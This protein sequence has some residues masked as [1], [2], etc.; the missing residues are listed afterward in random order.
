MIIYERAKS[1]HGGNPM[2]NIGIIGV[3]T[4]SSSLIRGFCTDPESAANMHFYL[5]PRGKTRSAELA[6]Q[7]PEQI[8]VCPD[9]QSVLDNSQWVFLTVLPRQGEAVMR[10][11]TFRP[12]HKVLSIMS[13]HSIAT[14]SSW[15]GTTEKLI[16]MVPL[17]FAAMHI[18]PIA[19]FPADPE[20][21]EMFAPLGQVI[22]TSRESELSIISALTAIMSAFY[23]LICDTSKW[24]EEQGLPADVSLAYMS[25]F[26]EALAVKGGKAPEGDIQG[27]AMEM[28]PGGLNEMAWKYLTE[29]D[30]FQEWCRALDQVMERLNR[31]KKN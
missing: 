6:A 19:S 10:E 4:I 8:T 14:V 1:P 3:G 27:L 31:G 21:R 12:D 17:P 26:F 29:K 24:G 18:G 5:S 15:I 23:Q 13:D 22:E 2:I 9:N 28:T 20:I 30:S 7:F 16:R 25:A 11:L